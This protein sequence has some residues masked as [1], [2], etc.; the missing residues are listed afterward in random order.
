[1][2]SAAVRSCCGSVFSTYLRSHGLV[3]R[4]PPHILLRAF[5][6][7]YPLVGGRSAGLGSR[8]GGEGAGGGHGGAGFVDESIFVERRDGGICNLAGIVLARP[9]SRVVDAVNDVQWQ[10]DRSQCGPSRATPPRAPCARDAACKS[11]VSIRG[12]GWDRMA[13]LTAHHS[14]GARSCSR[15]S[16][17]RR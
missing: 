7:H 12:A 14:G 8:V 1:M 4:S 10:R 6:F 11:L 9:L 2:Q 13:A 16:T 3:H 15:V 5:L 17:C